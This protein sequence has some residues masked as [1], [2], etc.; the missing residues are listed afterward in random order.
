MRIHGTEVLVADSLMLTSHTIKDAAAVT[1]MAESLPLGNR[2]ER[3][4]ASLVRP[5]DPR[6]L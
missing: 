1:I 4:K 3:G 5:V 6:I 2:R